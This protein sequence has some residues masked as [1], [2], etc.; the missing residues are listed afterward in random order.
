LEVWRVL[1]EVW[2]VGVCALGEGPAWRL[3]TWAHEYIGV[4][5]VTRLHRSMRLL[6]VWYWQRLK[7]PSGGFMLFYNDGF[8]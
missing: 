8:N 7:K 6:G 1:V 4:I 3:L 5:V 2:V